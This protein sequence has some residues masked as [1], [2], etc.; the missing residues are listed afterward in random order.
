MACYGP[1]EVGRLQPQYYPQMQPIP[2]P[3]P[4]HNLAVICSANEEDPYLSSAAS[5]Y[6]DL[7]MPQAFDINL[8]S[9]FNDNIVDPWFT[10]IAQTIPPHQQQKTRDP[11]QDWSIK[12]PEKQDIEYAPTE[13]RPV[14]KKRRSPLNKCRRRTKSET[15]FDCPLSP[16]D[17]QARSFICPYEECGKSYAK[18][19]HLRAHLRRHTGE[20]PFACQWP[21]CQWR[22]SRSDELAR[23]ERSHTGYKPYSCDICGKKFSRSDHLSK[24]I[25]IHSKPKKTKERKTRATGGTPRTRKRLESLQSFDDPLSPGYCPTPLASPSESSEASFSSA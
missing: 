19:S 11:T 2:Y 21:G 5:C 17:P 12:S 25:K 1:V 9:L 22:F 23:H 4:S 10:D 8:E 15:T 24:H 7:P 20:R 16:S 6:H 18:N 14:T 13:E 3:E